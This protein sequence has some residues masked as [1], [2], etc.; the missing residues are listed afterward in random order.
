MIK[1]ESGIFV[2]IYSNYSLFP[3]NTCLNLNLKGRSTK[4]VGNGNIKDD[5]IR[6]PRALESSSPRHSYICTFQSRASK[7]INIAGQLISLYS[8]LRSGPQPYSALT[9]TRVH[10]LKAAKTLVMVNLRLFAIFAFESRPFWFLGT[11]LPFLVGE[12][13]GSSP[14]V[15]CQQED[16]LERK[17]SGHIFCSTILLDWMSHRSC[18]YFNL[19][20]IRYL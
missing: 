7:P 3:A 14:F 2:N 5:L 8:S 9:C 18:R 17:V 13:D 15:V 6:A 12:T 16:Q 1:D 11:S 19:R 10:Q 20:S 4:S